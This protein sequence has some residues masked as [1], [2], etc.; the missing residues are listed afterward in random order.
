MS[1]LG[2]G[3]PFKASTSCGLWEGCAIVQKRLFPQEICMPLPLLH[4]APRRRPEGQQETGSASIPLEP[5]AR[6]LVPPTPA[7]WPLPLGLREQ[8]ASFILGLQWK[9]TD[10]SM[11]KPWDAEGEGTS[12]YHH[13]WP[14]VWLSSEAILV[15][16]NGFLAS[17]ATTN[18]IISSI[19]ASIQLLF[20]GKLTLLLE[21]KS[22][23]KFSH[24][25][26]QTP[27]F[28]LLNQ[29]LLAH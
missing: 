21:E 15:I 23:T 2:K 28:I 9:E 13:H 1:L 18:L 29:I 20:F 7:S 4:P 17:Q 19:E 14:V 16:L 24:L 22:K 10:G 5:E 8:G 11:Q 27:P 3:T 12:H 26:P 6:F 25:S